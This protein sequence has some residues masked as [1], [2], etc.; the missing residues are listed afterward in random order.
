M[1]VGIVWTEGKF[2]GVDF[3]E[4]VGQITTK[5]EKRARESLGEGAYVSR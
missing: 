4:T 5:K 2:L 3:P 1:V